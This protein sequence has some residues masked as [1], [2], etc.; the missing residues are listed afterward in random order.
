MYSAT[1]QHNL[2]YFPDVYNCI[3]GG[4]LMDR[5]PFID[6]I[7]KQSCI[8]NYL[9][10]QEQTGP[11]VDQLMVLFMNCCSSRVP[12]LDSDQILINTLSTGALT[13]KSLIRLLPEWFIE[14]ASFRE[15]VLGI[16]K[17]TSVNSIGI[18]AKLEITKHQMDNFDPFYWA[19]PMD[20]RLKAWSYFKEKRR[21]HLEHFSELFM[22]NYPIKPEITK[23]LDFLIEMLM[24]FADSTST[25][26]E[27]ALE[28]VLIVLK[29]VTDITADPECLERISSCI[30]KFKL[31]RNIPED[32]TSFLA[33]I[34]PPKDSE[35]QDVE[36]IDNESSVTLKERRKSSIMASFK[37]QRGVFIGEEPQ[38]TYEDDEH[39]CVVCSESGGQDLSF[40]IQVCETSLMSLS[41][42]KEK[43]SLMRGCYHLV[44]KK[45]FDSLPLVP[46]GAKFKMCTLCNSVI[47]TVIPL[48][49]KPR[50]VPNELKLVD[51]RDYVAE[52]DDEEECALSNPFDLLLR[53]FCNTLIY[54]CEAAV[55]VESIPLHQILTLTQMKRHLVEN[56]KRK[57]IQREIETDPAY[58]M[59]LLVSH[60]IFYA[61]DEMPVEKFSQIYKI[62]S[63][64]TLPAEHVNFALNLLML[65]TISKAEVMKSPAESEASGDSKKKTISGVDF[66]MNLIELPDRHDLFLKKYLVEQCKSC[67]TV[68][69]SAAVCLL[70]GTLVCVG[71]LCCRSGIK[72]G[73]G[74]CCSHREACSGAI[75]IFLIIKSCALLIVSESIGAVVPAP[76]VNV[77]GEHDFDL[78]SASALFLNKQLYYGKLTEMWRNCELRDF[79]LRNMD[80]SRINTHSWAML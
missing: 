8:M 25:D 70:C 63:E 21:S 33:T 7:M 57:P 4:H 74:E 78:S 44:H 28:M 72:N 56:L 42:N 46:N 2:T 29:A 23:E 60:F 13:K 75:G 79:I 69:K 17:L 11:I 5:A 49:T 65:E 18:D 15:K 32:I 16:A 27:F 66:K 38:A 31:K 47:D 77:F 3:I 40:P 34:S 61:R 58:M 1:S 6:M 64:S 35:S 26:Y 36:M 19:F 24:N 62:I 51:F 45:C 67:G 52:D 48:V 39:S 55:S 22:T 37:R 73:N 50:P 68:P 43:C 80:N 76:Y 59:K 41:S 14:E 10:I 53:V 12:D 20:L 71:Q 9:Q 54:H 30:K